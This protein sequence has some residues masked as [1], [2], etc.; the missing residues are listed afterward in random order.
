MVFRTPPT[1]S[2]VFSPTFTHRRRN[3]LDGLLVARDDRQVGQLGRRHPLPPRRRL[4]L[5]PEVRAP[6]GVQLDQRA[7]GEDAHQEPE[8]EEAALDGG[9]D[10][11]GEVAAAE[12]EVDVALEVGQPDGQGEECPQQEVE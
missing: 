2:T 8:E 6:V 9:D 3:E 12:A 7:E 11:E 5:L 4:G 10:V 1:Y